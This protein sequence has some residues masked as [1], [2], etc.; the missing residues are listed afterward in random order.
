VKRREVWDLLIG[1]IL[2]ALLSAFLTFGLA[3]AD[4]LGVG[5]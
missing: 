1:G 4:A 2:L 5:K 3:L